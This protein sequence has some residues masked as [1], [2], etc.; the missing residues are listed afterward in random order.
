MYQLNKKLI[1]I[2]AFIMLLGGV[3]TYEWRWSHA[4]IAQ[5]LQHATLLDNPREIPDFALFSAGHQPFNK[6]AVQGKWTMLFFGFTSCPSLC[7]TTMASLG[8]MYRILE[9]NQRVPLPQVVMVTLDPLRDKA[10]NLQAY[11]QGFDPHFTSARSEDEATVN[12]MARAIGI[13]SMKIEPQGNTQNYTFE[14]TGTV[15]L[16]NPKGQL[17][18]YF[19][20]PHKPQELAHDYT[21]VVSKS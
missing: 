6:A 2:I 13:A 7:P 19:T 21:I 15:M 16:L 5:S 4:A 10:E 14:H 8:K 3:L 20:M 9:E 1:F 18:A 17:A 12:A 11:V